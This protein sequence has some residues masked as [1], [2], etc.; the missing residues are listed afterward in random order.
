MMIRRRV[1]LGQGA[2]ALGLGTTALLGPTRTAQAA[3]RAGGDVPAAHVLNRLGFGPRPG[4]LATVGRDPSAWIDAQLKP[5]ELPLPAALT[6]KLR[7]SQF[8]DA[9]PIAAVREYV[10]IAAQNNLQ[11]NV[12]RSMEVGGDAASMQM[13]PAAARQAQ[14]GQGQQ[15]ATPLGRLVRAHQLP[16]LESRLFRALESPRQLEEVM[17]DFWFNHFNIYQ[18][19]AFTRVLVGHYEHYAIRPFA[20]GRFRDLL[21]ATAHHPAMLYYLDNW[22]SSVEREG[23]RD[24]GGGGVGDGI[25][26][27]LNE[28]YARELMELHTLG[29]DDGYTQADVTQLARM[30]TGWTLVPVRQRRAEALLAPAVRVVPPGHPADIP[31]FWFNPRQ[32]DRGEKQWLGQRVAARGQA[33]GDFALDTLAAHPATARHIGFKLA[34]YFVSDRP[35]PALVARLAQVFKAEDGQIVPVLRALFESDAFWAPD[36]VGAKFKTPYHFALSAL[37]AAGH[38]PANVIALSTQLASQ[39]MPLFGC[40]TPDGYKNTEAAWLNPDGMSKRINFATQLAQLFSR[41]RDGV[42]VDALVAELGP[43]VTPATRRLVEQNR[44]DPSLAMALVLAGPGMMRR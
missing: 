28:N 34:Q 16:A 43:L 3:S 31:G 26:R 18:N 7:E 33:E 1:V 19:K 27:G 22:T 42:D 39:G 23:P 6:A 29:V 2:A 5:S 20:M 41:S 8:V 30:L 40:Q 4:D 24:G 25:R 44:Q 13:N 21:G 11:P 36:S 15:A 17:V 32:H 12:A 14:A 9:D 10:S 37:R 35:D 38:S